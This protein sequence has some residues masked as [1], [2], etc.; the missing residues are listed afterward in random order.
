MLQP[1]LTSR[2]YTSIKSIGKE[3]WSKVTD[4][5]NPF[6]QY[7]FLHALET[8][9]DH[10]GEEIFIACSKET[11]WQPYHLA[12]FENNNICA[13]I[14]IYIKYH[15]YG[16]YIF[17]WTWANAYAQHNLNYYPKLLSSI[18]FTP[19]EGPRFLFKNNIKESLKN[20]IY[21]KAVTLLKK[22]LDQHQLSSL[23]F[24]YTTA[25]C[26]SLLSDHGLAQRHSYQ[27]H[28][29]NKKSNGKKYSDFSDFLSCLKSR[30]RKS[31]INERKSLE[32]KNLTIKKLRG[33][34]ITP[35]LWDRFYYFYQ[36]T[37]AKKSGHGGYL[38]KAFFTTVTK[39]MDKNMLMVTCSNKEEIIAAALFFFT[40][41]TLYGRYWGSTIDIPGLHFEC[42][43]YQGIEFCIE[44]SLDLFN[45]GA[46]GEHKIQ[47]GFSPVITYSNHWLKDE[48]FYKAVKQ[49]INV[50]KTQIQEHCNYANTLLPFNNR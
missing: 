33:E 11:G 39:F 47:R 6:I 37:Y 42:C 32:G 12:F 14:P 41:S 8:A 45:A 5:E 34:E 22:T 10:N 20:A 36:L 38:P 18:P 21:E 7:D 28:W 50:E 40:S 24:L 30:K 2:F 9:Y 17:D 19:I 15:S 1:D 3:N 13:A 48:A 43:Y 35:E 16:E 4:D 49:Y 25:S 31:I 46:Q 27:Y 23:H 26:S 29:L 44:H